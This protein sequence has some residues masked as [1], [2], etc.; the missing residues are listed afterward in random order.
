MNK[1]AFCIA[2]H[3]QQQ[4]CR[5]LDF[6]ISLTNTQ[7]NQYGNAIRYRTKNRTWKGWKTGDM[8]KA[9]IPKGKYAGTYPVGRVTAKQRDSFKFTVPSI[10]AFHVHCKYLTRIHR[11][12]RYGYA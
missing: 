7:T 4:K 6:T 11:K 2:D 12:D 5:F 3:P 8:A 1:R 9:S 10:P